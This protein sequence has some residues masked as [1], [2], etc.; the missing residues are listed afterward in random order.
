MVEKSPGARRSRFLKTLLSQLLVTT[1]PL[2]LLGGLSGWSAALSYACGAGCGLIP[3]CF[4]ALR[5]ERA[6]RQSPGRAA[7]AGLAAE[8]GK[9]LLSAAAFAVVFAVIRPTSP[10]LVFV[11]FAA[12]WLAQLWEAALLL[13]TPR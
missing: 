11:G 9:F 5:M 3:Q 7:R 13:R 6:V 12:V 1:V 10:L 8:G 4:F 2:P